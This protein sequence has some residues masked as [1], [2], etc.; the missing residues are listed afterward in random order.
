MNSIGL[1]GGL[2]WRSTIEYYK[3]INTKI[4]EHFGKNTNPPL[5]IYN[6]D[7]SRI[8]QLQSQDDWQGIADTFSEII[9]KFKVAGCT[10][11][12]LCSNTSHRALDFMSLKTSL[13]EIHIGKSILAELLAKNL[14]RPLFLGTKY[15][16][17]NDFILRH[18]KHENITIDLPELAT[19]NKMHEL[20]IKNICHGDFSI[21]KEFLDLTC[22][23]LT[24]RN[25]AII[26]G[27]TDFMPVFDDYNDVL[28]MDSVQ[29]HVNLICEEILKDSG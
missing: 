9:D 16:M 20:Y 5:L 14:K 17:Q 1:I 18:L 2:A 12:V 26:S 4:N 3:G 27:C 29:C 25:D 28:V 13:P 7:Q 8:H 21:A 23:S 15:S 19:Q 24:P 6:V 22:N 10:K 11:F